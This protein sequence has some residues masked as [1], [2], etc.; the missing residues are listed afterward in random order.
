MIISLPGGPPTKLNDV[1]EGILVKAVIWP[2]RSYISKVLHD[3]DEVEAEKLK[4]SMTVALSKPHEELGMWRILGT[5]FC[6]NLPDALLGRLVCPGFFALQWQPLSSPCCCLTSCP[7]VIFYFGE[8][9]HI[10]SLHYVLYS[11]LLFT[12]STAH[13]CMLFY[14]LRA[15]FFTLYTL[16]TL[17]SLL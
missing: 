7:I 6:G 17:Y 16:L 10:C 9:L 2:L 13:Y 8:A 14:L 4:N 12:L 3:H 15:L 1:L 5:S 11:L